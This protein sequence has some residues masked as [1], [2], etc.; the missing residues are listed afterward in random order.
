MLGA[1]AGKREQ[2]LTASSLVMFGR[3]QHS[4]SPSH[5][6]PGLLTRT[7]KLER[8]QLGYTIDSPATPRVDDCV[9]PIFIARQTTL[10]ILIISRG[11]VDTD[12]FLCLPPSSMYWYHTRNCFLA[13]FRKGV[14]PS[15]SAHQ[16]SLRRGDG[17]WEKYFG[18]STQTRDSYQVRPHPP[19]ISPGSRLRLC[20]SRGYSWAE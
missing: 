17:T 18:S 8:Q 11:S 10:S 14:G 3:S 1:W 20:M 16:L 6:S 13:Q 2:F 19:P 4:I 12:R 5:E 7:G 15:Q 9:S